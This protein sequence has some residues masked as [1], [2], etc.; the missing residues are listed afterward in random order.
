M[1]AQ[2]VAG[3]LDWKHRNCNRFEPERKKKVERREPSGMQLLYAS[4]ITEVLV[5]LAGYDF[6]AVSRLL[7]GGL[8]ALALVDLAMSP[9]VGNDGEVAAT[10]LDLASK[11]YNKISFGLQWRAFG[12]YASRQCGC[13]CA[14]ARNSD[15]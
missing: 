7:G 9:Q 5:V 4:N 12:T 10:A 2:Y 8:V 13:T 14:S 3:Y 11:C 15:G 1:N 6:Y